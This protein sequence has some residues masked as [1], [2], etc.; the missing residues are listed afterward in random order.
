L[1]KG[2]HG[3]FLRIGAEISTPVSVRGPGSSAFRADKSLAVILHLHPSPTHTVITAHGPTLFYHL[4]TFRTNFVF[5]RPR[6]RSLHKFFPNFIIC[7][8]VLYSANLAVGRTTFFDVESVSIGA[9]F[10]EK[11]VVR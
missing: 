2:L 5:F 6:L 3:D 4:A 11:F 9:F 8:F 10:A 1:G 7:L